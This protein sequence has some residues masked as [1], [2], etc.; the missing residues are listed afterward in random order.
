M[1][2]LKMFKNLSKQIL[3]NDLT[4]KS[5]KEAQ[6][7]H[8]DKFI[9]LRVELFMSGVGEFMPHYRGEQKYGWDIRPGIFRPP[10]D[11][12]DAKNGK[13]L[14]RK[15]IAEFENVIT[16]EIGSSALRSLYENEKHGKDWDLLFQAQHAGVKTT[17]TDWTAFI[18]RSLYFTVEESKDTKIEQSDAQLWCLMVPEANIWGHNDFPIRDSFY[19]I[20]PFNIS[21][22][23]M[24]NPSSYLHEIEKRIFE[25][26]MFRQGGRFLISPNDI[27]NIPVNSQKEISDFFF[28]IRIPAQY[29]KPIRDELIAIDVTRQTMFVDENPKHQSLIDE[30]NAKFFHV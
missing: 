14:E 3:G 21:G 28:K 24:I 19:D 25:Y 2:N 26:R 9:K 22:T 12:L 27:C 16:K 17:L 30:I 29:K 15:G 1:D 7:F 20:D 5:A 23:Y 18:I 6:Q 4:I 13:D 10:L 8:D 11:K